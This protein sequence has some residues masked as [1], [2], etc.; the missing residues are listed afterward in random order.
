MNYTFKLFN[1]SAF[2]L[3]IA[4]TAKMQFIFGGD[5]LFRI[6]TAGIILA[7]ILQAFIIQ[8]NKEVKADLLSHLFLVNHLCLLI[9][10]T[11]MM[12]KVAHVMHTQ[13][14]KDLILDFFGIPATAI[15]MIYTF[16]KVHVIFKSSG[17]NKI[18]FYKHILLPWCLFL[19]SFILY[20]VYS[21]VLA[22][23]QS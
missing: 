8:K 14:E 20:A 2:F 19:F 4:W 5:Y 16:S 21:L 6:A 15:A 9:V 23:S 10:Y 13:F 11:G 3:F 22:I 7:L 18:L 1:L 17:S 12:L